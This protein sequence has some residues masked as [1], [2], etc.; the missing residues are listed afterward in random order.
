MDQSPPHT[1][2]IRATPSL[3]AH[4][5]AKLG[6]LDEFRLRRALAE[7][8]RTGAVEVTRGGRQLISFSCNDYLN[9]SQHPDVARAAKDAIAQGYSDV[10]GL[11]YEK[12]TFG[13]LF[14]TPDQREGMEAFVENR[15]PEFQ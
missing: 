11:D 6:D 4:A 3:D 12:R 15:E 10:S 2:P 1:S 13:S 8:A 7:T 14:G 5:A 9:L